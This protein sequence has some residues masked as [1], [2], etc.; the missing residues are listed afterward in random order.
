MRVTYYTVGEDK[1]G[2]LVAD[3]S[4]K[5]AKPGITCAAH[6]S[7][8]FGTKLHIPQLK[9]VVGDGTFIVQDRGGAVNKRTASKG[10]REVI[11]IFVKDKK[12]MKRLMRS[13]PMNM[14]VYVYGND[15]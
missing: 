14:K 8:K 6:K 10:K 3:P 4:V 9:G 5:R 13:Q 7:R 2:S 1:Y 12:T 11:D 15:K